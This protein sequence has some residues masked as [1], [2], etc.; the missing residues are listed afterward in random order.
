MRLLSLAP[1]ASASA[2]FAIR[3]A[4]VRGKYAIS[5]HARH[6]RATYTSFFTLP[7]RQL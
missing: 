7:V 6:L 3:P 4:S 5:P 1:E 2:S